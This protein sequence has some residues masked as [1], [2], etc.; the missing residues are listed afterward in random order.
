MDSTADVSVKQVIWDKDIASTE[1]I[2]L[3]TG[4][5]L[6]VIHVFLCPV[7]YLFTKLRSYKANQL[8]V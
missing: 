1:D 4:Q 5:V 2:T 6:L 3:S 7:H 8:P